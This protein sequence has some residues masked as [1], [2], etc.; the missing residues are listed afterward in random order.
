MKITHNFWI[1]THKILRFEN[2]FCALSNNFA[3]EKT[4]YYKIDNEPTLLGRCRSVST[5]TSLDA[6]IVVALVS[7]AN[8]MFKGTN[9]LD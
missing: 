4:S 8:M 5:F 7:I 2:S 3:P 1:F 6:I 9:K